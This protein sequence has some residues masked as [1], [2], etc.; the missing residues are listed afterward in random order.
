MKLALLNCYE[1]FGEKGNGVDYT[2]AG[3]GKDQAL[4][5]VAMVLSIENAELRQETADSPLVGRWKRALHDL[6]TQ[7]AS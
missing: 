3:Q 2:A 6:F 5:Q 4:T 7:P 1:T